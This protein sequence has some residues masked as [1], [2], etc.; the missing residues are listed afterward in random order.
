MIVALHRIQSVARHVF[1]RHKPGGVVACA[2]L[3]AFFFNA[4]YAQALAL[5]Q[6]VERQ[7]HMLADGALIRIFNW[8]W[9]LRDVAV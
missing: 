3:R 7:A 4:A 8:A 6:G 9:R 2:A 1:A 5:A